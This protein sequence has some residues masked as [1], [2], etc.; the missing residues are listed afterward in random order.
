M[1]RDIEYPY[2]V[3]VRAGKELHDVC[4][5]GQRHL[6]ADLKTL[7]LQGTC[8][9]C[10]VTGFCKLQQHLTGQ[11]VQAFGMLACKH[12][13]KAVMEVE[14]HDIYAEGEMAML[15]RCG[16]SG[17]V[18]LSEGGGE[19]RDMIP[20]EVAVDMDPK[21]QVSTNSRCCLRKPEQR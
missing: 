19:L 10:L 16:S 21:G 14:L 17:N 9:L 15:R 4:N 3:S 1:K 18:R 5:F 2:H 20:G 7:E 6:P 8:S 11:T 13:M 12:C